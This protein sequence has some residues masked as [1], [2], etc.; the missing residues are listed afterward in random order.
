MN[1]H[2]ELSRFDVPP[3]LAQW[4][5]DTLAKLHEQVDNGTREAQRLSAQLINQQQVLAAKQRQAEQREELL[6]ARDL[7]IQALTLELAHLRRIRYGVRSEALTAEQRDLFQE[8]W[9]ADIEAAQ[10]SLE[11]LSPTPAEAPAQPRQRAH[12]GRQALPD[13]LPRIDY[14]HEPQSCA[15]AQCG[16][17]LTQIGEDISEKLDMEP[18]RFFVNRHIRPQYACRAC[19]TISAAPLPPAIIDGGLGA[20]GLFVWVIISKYVDH[21]PL[22]R[23][24]QIAARQ[25][26]GLTRVTLAQWV[27]RIGVALEP[28]ADRLA[29]LLRQRL[30]LHA[31]ETPVAQLNPGAGKTKRAYLWAY[32]SNV[33]ETGPPLVVFDYQ[34]TRAGVHARTFLA[35]WAGHLMVDDFGGYKALFDNGV[36]ELACLAHARRKFFEIQAAS[37]SP[38]AAEALVRIGQLYQIEAQAKDLGVPER[39]GL[40]ERYAQPLL[41]QLREWMISTRMSVAEGSGTARALDYSLKRW[42]AL[43]RYA[44]RGD[45]PIDNNPVENAIRPIALG[46]KNW[47]FTGSE[48]AGKRAAAIQSLLGTA[49]LNGLDPALWLRDTLEK[50][51]LWPNS[52]IDELLPL[53]RSTTVPACDAGV[54]G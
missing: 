39:A 18:A 23:L 31:D 2:A 32:H 8:T 43:S 3:E 44:T 9:S 49:K 1:L 16:G 19:E 28:L 11:H 26:V 54:V 50:L 12:P 22:Y 10:A 51:P 42:E 7:K 37:P 13:H 36:I 20:V 21:L 38:I 47:L 48:R 52:R 53:R 17:A 33:L 5:S 35:G 14:R 45:L 15:C 40:R 27:G 4:V 6:K 46:R 41:A 24:E 34:S 30:I 25:G 29:E